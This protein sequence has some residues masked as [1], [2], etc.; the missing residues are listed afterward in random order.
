MSFWEHGQRVA[1]AKEAKIKPHHLSEILHRKRGV[2]KTTA[3]A[4]EAASQHVLGR[5]IPV[6]CWL[7]NQFTIHPAFFGSHKEGLTYGQS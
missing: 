5:A 2:G 1:I 6:T 3:A 7:Y 4:L